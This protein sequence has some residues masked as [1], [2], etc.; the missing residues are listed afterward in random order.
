[1]CSKLPY[2]WNELR[3]DVCI[4]LLKNKSLKACRSA[5]G[6]EWQDVR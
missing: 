3:P 4:P 1:M 2:L 6:E 5:I